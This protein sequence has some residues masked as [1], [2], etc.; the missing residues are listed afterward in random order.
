MET[1]AKI[2]EITNFILVLIL[3]MRNG[4]QHLI[5]LCHIVP[6]CIVLIL[7]MRNG[8]YSFLKEMGAT[9]NFGSYPTYEE[10]K[11]TGY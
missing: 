9:S 7:P 8:N 6:L 4:N 1:S 5:F 3:P 11:H 2:A 10:W